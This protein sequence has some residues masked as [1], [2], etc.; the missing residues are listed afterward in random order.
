MTEANTMDHS[1]L[2]FAFI[3]DG[4][5]GGQSVSWKEIEEWKTS[6]GTLWVNLAGESPI[7]EEWLRQKS[8]LDAITC[9]ALTREDVR[10]RSMLTGSGLLTILRGINLNPGD[11]PEDMVSVRIYIENNRII[12]A[13]HRFVRSIDDLRRAIEANEGPGTV[14]EFLSGLGLRLVDRMSDMIEKKSEEVDELEEAIVHEYSS[15][16]A[17]RLANVRRQIV[18]L[19]RHLAP[20]RE[21]LGRIPSFRIEFLNEEDL[22]RLRE[23]MDQTMH[24]IEELDSARDRAMV[25]QE[26]LNNRLSKQLER[27]MYALSLIAAIFLPLSFLTGLLG[28]NVG[29]IPG[30]EKHNGF[31]FVA[32]ILSVIM[33]FQL[34]LFKK[35]KWI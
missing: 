24:F 17:E 5:G 16:I 12:T 32:I 34:L 25:T 31:L 29:G 21:A 35:M 3:L 19:R 4:Q 10:P 22:N 8:G 11:D 28:I 18:S 1:G 14:G 20:Q 13:R 33:G 9:D 26:E 30:A 23:V 15:E 7:A 27:R 6:S 2:I